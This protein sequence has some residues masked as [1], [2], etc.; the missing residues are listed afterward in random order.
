MTAGARRWSRRQKGTPARQRNSSHKSARQLQ[1]LVRQHGFRHGARRLLRQRAVVEP[2]RLVQFTSGLGGCVYRPMS[3]GVSH[4][5]QPPSEAA[6]E[7]ALPDRKQGRRAQ[8]RNEADV[9]GCTGRVVSGAKRLVV[10]SRAIVGC[11]EE[12]CAG[13]DFAERCPVDTADNLGGQEAALDAQRAPIVRTVGASRIRRALEPPVVKPD[14]SSYM[15]LAASSIGGTG[16]TNHERG[17]GKG[18]T[19]RG[20]PVVV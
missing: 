14:R 8:I 12:V 11:S 1:A 13:P 7:L 19:D 17:E 2:D 20:I 16:P 15:I 9:P 10:A 18:Y 3:G 6:R 4:N 5:E